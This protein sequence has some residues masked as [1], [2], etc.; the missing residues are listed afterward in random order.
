VLSGKGAYQALSAAFV[1]RLYNPA[2]SGVELMMVDWPCKW[3]HYRWSGF[4]KRIEPT[5]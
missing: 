1:C 3:F 5:A 2:F 4:N